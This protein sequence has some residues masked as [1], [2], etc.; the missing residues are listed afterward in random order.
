MSEPQTPYKIEYKL[1]VRDLRKEYPG[2]TA[3]DGVS[4]GFR[5][6]EVHALLG[7][8]GAGKSTLVKILSGAVEPTSGQ[9]L[10]DGEAVR[11]RSPREAFVRGIA[12]VYQELSLIPEF[13]VGEN[14]LFG[15]LPRKGAMID[16]SQVFARTQEVLAQM[17]VDLDVR[18]KVSQLGVA[19]QQVV[20]I[21]KAMSFDPKVLLLDEP[22]SALAHHEAQSLFALIRNLAARDVAIVYISHRLHFPS[23][24][25]TARG[26]R[27]DVGSA[28]R[29]IHR[30][31]KH[32]RRDA[33]NN[34]AHNVWRGRSASSP[35]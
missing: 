5:G 11:L 12:T 29:K 21:A 32:G 6:G 16:W 27:C 7:K 22:T 35:R 9:L 1:E 18:Q 10:I 4:L 3:L 34:R 19:S 8:N 15:R 24:A 25:G 17:G 31:D 23:L 2:T 26:R 14:I 33:R 30:H 13:T 28:R 20:E